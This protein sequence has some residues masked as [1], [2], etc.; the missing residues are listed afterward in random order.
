MPDR[1]TS[2]FESVL[3]VWSR[4][5]WLVLACLTTLLIPITAVVLSLPDVYRASATVLIERRH[6][7][8]T[9]VRS[10]VSGE[11]ETRLQTIS[12]KML[13]RSRLGDVIAH[14]DLYPELRRRS[15][16][17]AAIERMRRDIQ[18]EFKA[19]EQPGGR[20]TLAFTVSY[21]GADPETVA[22]VTNVLASFHVEENLRVRKRAASGAVEFLKRQLDETAQRLGEQERR[23]AEFKKRHG[24]ELPQQV[25]VNLSILERLNS[26]LRLTSDALA[27]AI[28]RRAMLARPLDGV[29]PGTPT[30]PDTPA[31]RL[32]RLKRELR[33]LTRRYTDKYPEV[34]R[35][36]AEIAAAEEDMATAGREARPEPSAA[37]VS[38]PTLVRLQDSLALADTEIK[39]LR[40]EEQSL[41]REIDEYRARLENAPQREQDLQEVSR[42]YETTK[43]LYFSLLK[44]YEEATLAENMEQ[45]QRGDEFRILDPA[46][47]SPLPSAPNRLKLLLFGAALSLGGTVA[48]TMFVEHVHNVFHTVDDLRTVTRLPIVASIP[49]IVTEVDRRRRRR[50]FM[51]AAVS[52]VLCLTILAAVSHHVATGNY[53]LVSMLSRSRS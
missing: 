49:L 50:R 30:T 37:A 40:G 34:V 36:K 28:E 35:V 15:S 10:S 44:R 43:D 18:L 19:V 14:F 23:V 21:Q 38:D 4:R 24:V 27:R 47:P 46:I 53:Q 6:M 9:F 17:E 5:R 33:D 51:L 16:L 8:E 45:Q 2:T 3:E 32:A 7:A 26:Q 22:L 42:T 13:S 1:T 25:A 31:V 41:R 52:A 39:T 11:L 12:E 48:L 29:V 20:A